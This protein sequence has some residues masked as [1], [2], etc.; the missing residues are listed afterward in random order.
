[1]Q[2]APS[3]ALPAR[4]ERLGD[5]PCFDFISLVLV[6]ARQPGVIYQC[7]AVQALMPPE[8]V[9]G[10]RK[11]RLAQTPLPGK[12]VSIQAGLNRLVQGAAVA[13]KKWVG[14]SGCR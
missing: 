6:Q 9:A 2:P 5:E 8:Q 12:S 14:F 10:S 1:M 11:S 7:A 4:S 13:V 3:Q